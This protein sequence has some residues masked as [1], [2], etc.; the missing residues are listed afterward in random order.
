MYLKSGAGVSGQ[1]KLIRHDISGIEGSGPNGEVTFHDLWELKISGG[2]CEWVSKH[3]ESIKEVKTPQNKITKRGLSY[4]LHRALS[5]HGGGPYVPSDISYSGDSNPFLAFCLLADDPDTGGGGAGAKDADARVGWDESDGQYDTKIPR[6]VANPGEGKRGILLSVTSGTF[7][8]LSTVYPT[9]APY[10]EIEYTFFAPS[11]TP[12]FAIGSIVVDFASMPSD[13]DYFTL[14]DGIHDPLNFEFDTNDSITAGNVRVDVSAAASSQDVVDRLVEAIN[15]E[16]FRLHINA[17]DAGSS[18]ISLQHTTGGLIGQQA[19]T[20]SWVLGGSWAFAGMLGGSATET[21]EAEIDNLPIKSLCMA[22]A[23]ACGHD[24]ASSMVGLRSIVGVAPTQQGVSDRVYIHEGSGLHEYIATETLG[25]QGNID[26]YVQSGAESE[27]VRTIA[28]SGTDSITVLTR[29]VIMKNGLFQQNEVGYNFVISGSSNGNDGTY[30]IQTVVNGMTIILASAPPGTNEG[31]GFAGEVMADNTGEG[32]FDGDI[33]SEVDTGLVDLGPLKWR[34]VDSSG[35]H[36]VGRI[37]GAADKAV[38][39]IRII[40]PSG[41][42]KDNYPDLFKVQYLDVTKAPGLNPNNLEPADNNHWTDVVGQ[43]YTS[44]SQD[45]NIYNNE[46]RG[47]EYVFSAPI[48]TRGIRLTSMLASDSTKAV[49]IGELFIFEDPAIITLTSGVNDAIKLATDGVPGG[50]IGTYRTFEL[51]D[52][53]TTGDALNEDVQAICDAINAQVR[54][55]ELEAIRSEFG[56]LWVRCTVAGDNSRLDLDSEA[57]GST[58]NSDIGLDVAGETDKAGT[59]EVMR[60]YPAD[61]FT[62]I[63][64]AAISGDLPV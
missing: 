37:W 54:G 35:P 11:S 14:N 8:R 30:V 42:P 2:N 26:G 59:T 62:F 56:F 55:Y 19:I 61:S 45:D 40:G 7:Y 21:G 1:F 53:V 63:Y 60:K 47:Y 27:S 34:S 43:D 46:D 18:T 6:T 22:N 52:L 3:P 29:R 17:T 28:A 16:R 13:G 32:C 48:Y 24:E 15:S 41:T 20:Y 58:V 10:R 64:R 31:N 49:E 44:S 5:A 33:E 38:R 39:G 23:V 4:I 51:G 9:T 36:T 25:G 57:N 12:T 50:A